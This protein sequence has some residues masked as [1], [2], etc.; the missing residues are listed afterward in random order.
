MSKRV[1]AMAL[2]I[3]AFFIFVGSPFEQSAAAVVVLDDALI[4]VIIAALAACGISIVAAE[5]YETVSD[6]VTTLF[7]RY[8]TANS[9][10]ISEQTRGIQYGRD[11]S[12]KILVNNRFLIMISAF[13]EWLRAELG[14]QNNSYKI[15]SSD[16]Y[17]TAT[18]QDDVPVYIP[19]QYNDGMVL[20]QNTGL[21]DP[22]PFFDGFIGGVTYHLSSGYYF[23][24][25]YDLSDARY[26]LKIARDSEM[27]DVLVNNKF[28]VVDSSYI[29]AGYENPIVNGYYRYWNG[30]N[31]F[32]LGFQTASPGTGYVDQ[33][34]IMLY[35]SYWQ[36]GA[37]NDMTLKTGSGARFSKTIFEQYFLPSLT[38]INA[39]TGV[40]NPP[41]DASDYEE[42]DGAL[43]DVGADWGTTLPDILDDL[44]PDALTDEGE[45][46]A[47]IEYQAEEEVVEQLTED[48]VASISDNPASYQVP[49]LQNVFPFCIPF[50][51]YAFFECLAADP[52]APS[53][54]WRFYIPGIC[55]EELEIDLAAFDSA[56]R[57]LRTMELL[58]FIVGLAFVTRDKFLRG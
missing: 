50:D 33:Y 51:I 32:P 31:K 22:F 20:G 6:Y 52:V 39:I 14:L 45:I 58:L 10:S 2:A 19:L 34:F 12:G 56:A 5:G 11:K 26:G 17:I 8:C 37:S 7:G 41:V 35:A 18:G 44:I 38:T 23:R 49:G 24:I 28:E 36:A 4:A 43:I 47:S 54:T 46:D 3:L 27:T 55:D 40:I 13:I 25:D 42:G 48:G 15:V 53:F 1:L 29:N 9:T 21:Y 30:Y 16:M 57:I